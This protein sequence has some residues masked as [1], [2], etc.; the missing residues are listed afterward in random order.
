MPRGGQE[1][2]EEAVMIPD[3]DL[4]RKVRAKILLSNDLGAGTGSAMA[5][6]ETLAASVGMPIHHGMSMAEG[7]ETAAGQKRKSN[8]QTEAHRL[9]ESCTLVS[10]L[11]MVTAT[12]AALVAWGSSADAMRLVAVEEMVFLARYP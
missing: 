6:L 11:E 12:G 1:E 10:G 2:V 3:L 9:C 4:P 7:I 8:N 5:L